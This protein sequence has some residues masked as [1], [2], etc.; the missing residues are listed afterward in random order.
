MAERIVVVGHAAVTC[1]GRDLDATWDGLLAGRGGLR[2][3]PGFV[4]E[5]FLCDV[6]GRV[7]DF[8][9]GSADEDPAV[10]KLEVRSVHLAMAAARAAW[11]DAGLDRAGYDP[12]RVAVIVGSAQGGLDTF[13]A[14]HDDAIGRR[15]LETHQ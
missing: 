1:L 9:P 5:R 7:D 8:G 15:R 6:A 10:A 2:R 12:D 11:A 3:H 4:P 14:A 13:S